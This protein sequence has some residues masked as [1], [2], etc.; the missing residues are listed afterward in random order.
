[1]ASGQSELLS[2]E[3]LVDVLQQLGVDSDGAV[4]ID[5]WRE[6]PPELRS[7]LLQQIELGQQM[8]LLQD[9]PGDM[10]AAMAA[11]RQMEHDMPQP[12]H[13]MTG[14]ERGGQAEVHV[15]DRRREN[16]GLMYRRP[17]YAEDLML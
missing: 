3:L 4:S 7:L 2:A 17:S 16:D 14:G 12:H 1:V 13:R 8:S 10:G 6:L 5:R 9:G 11:F 15:N